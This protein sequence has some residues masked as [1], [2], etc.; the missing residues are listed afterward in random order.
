MLGV[1]F[2]RS[3]YTRSTVKSREDLE[4]KQ[5][6]YLELSQTYTEPKFNVYVFSRVD[7]IAYKKNLILKSYQSADI[8]ELLHYHQCDSRSS[9]KAEHLKCLLNLQIQHVHARFAVFLT[10][11]VTQP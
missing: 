10:G 7:S 11:K 9:T 5:Q 2:I 3:G 4:I 8:I 6:N 1:G